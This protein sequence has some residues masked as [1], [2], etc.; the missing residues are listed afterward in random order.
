MARLVLAALGTAL[1]AHHSDAFAPRGFFPTR[2]APAVSLRRPLAG[3][4]SAKAQYAGNVGERKVGD[5]VI[6]TDGSRLVSGDREA[7]SIVT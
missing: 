4:H 5:S 1:L 7:K 6:G 2:R 3:L